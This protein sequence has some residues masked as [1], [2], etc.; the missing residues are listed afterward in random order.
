[1]LGVAM[2]AKP[3]R[4]AEVTPFAESSKVTQDNAAKP[5]RCSATRNTSGAGF[6]AA[7]ASPATITENKASPRGAN[8]RRSKPSTFSR[9][10]SSGNS[11]PHSSIASFPYQPRDARPQGDSAF[12]QTSTVILGLQL[13]NARKFAARRSQDSPGTSSSDNARFALS[14]PV[15]R[16]SSLIKRRTMEFL[17]FDKGPIDVENQGFQRHRALKRLSPD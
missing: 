8:A 9:V 6:S 12:L 7:T 10:R 17:A 11:K 4:C 2:A 14:P 3:A 16:R 13:M 15:V 1:M 5:S